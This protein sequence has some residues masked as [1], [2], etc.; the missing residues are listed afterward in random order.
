MYGFLFPSL[1]RPLTQRGLPSSTTS[2]PFAFFHPLPP[3]HP[4]SV[5]ARALTSTTVHFTCRSLP[6][7]TPPRAITLVYVSP[8]RRAHFVFS[9]P[10]HPTEC[11]VF[12][13]NIAPFAS[14]THSLISS[15]LSLFICLT[16]FSHLRLS[17]RAPLS[18][19]TTPRASCS[20]TTAI[21]TS[22]PRSSRASLTACAPSRS[23][24]T[25]S[26]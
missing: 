8:Q 21:T 6:I 16:N 10:F 2:F 22:S 7:K 12:R 23:S 13:S 15:C 3:S 1:F 11:I 18:S 17:P 24:T 26:H 19:S 20:T 14:E 5:R 25:F 4:A 9:N